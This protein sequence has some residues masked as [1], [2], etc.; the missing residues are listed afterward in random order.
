MLG[1]LG[2]YDTLEEDEDRDWVL[3]LFESSTQKK[4]KNGVK[5]TQAVPIWL[6]II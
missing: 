4:N 1:G 2:Q 5:E 6:Q 3:L